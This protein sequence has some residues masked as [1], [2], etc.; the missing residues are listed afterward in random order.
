MQERVLKK[1]GGP[2]GLLFLALNHAVPCLLCLQ[3]WES[4]LR[5]MN[6]LSNRRAAS[7]SSP[8]MRAHIHTPHTHTHTHSMRCLRRH[9]WFQSSLAWQGSVV[10]L[11]LSQVSEEV[12]HEL[13]GNTD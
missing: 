5:P 4:E 6:G 13:G 11:N 9:P 12:D 3:S 10:Q 1:E 8:H 2:G 7:L